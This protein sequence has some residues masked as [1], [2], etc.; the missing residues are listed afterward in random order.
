MDFILTFLTD[1]VRLLKQSTLD[2]QIILVAFFLVFL[3]IIGLLLVLSAWTILT[4]FGTLLDWW[5]SQK[6]K[7]ETHQKEIINKI[8]NEKKKKK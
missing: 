6:E 5:D 1:F 2:Q 7:N 8:K 4:F 3:F